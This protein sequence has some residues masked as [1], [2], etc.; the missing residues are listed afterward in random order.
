MKR[1]SMLKLG[2]TAL[3]LAVSAQYSLAAPTALP[4]VQHQGNVTFLSGGIGLSES[5]AIKNAMSSYPLMLEFA[6]KTQ[7]G[8]EYLADIPVQVSDMN[9]HAVLRTTTTGPFLLASLPEGRYSVT[10]SYNG[11]SEHREVNITPSAHIHEVFVW[12]M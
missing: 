8:N 3:V 2:F 6:G 1:T 12:T 5:T 9:G 10:A 7:S 11:K 4:P